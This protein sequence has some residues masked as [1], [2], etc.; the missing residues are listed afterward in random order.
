M[1]NDRELQEL[2]MRSANSPRE[3]GISFSASSGGIN[4]DVHGRGQGGRAFNDGELEEILMRG[5]VGAAARSDSFQ[6][7]M[8]GDFADAGNGN[9]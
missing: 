3:S 4:P 2:L 7:P 5:D 6:R 9:R 8:R 1:V